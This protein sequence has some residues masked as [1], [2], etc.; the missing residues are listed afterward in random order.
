MFAPKAIEAVFPSN[1]LDQ[2]KTQHTGAMR[3]SRS[4]MVNKDHI[5]QTLTIT[6]DLL[7][8]NSEFPLKSNF[9]VG[10]RLLSI[11]VINLK[12]IE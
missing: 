7:C 3:R 5:D 1:R 8:E 11:L 10:G 6:K 2:Y 4:I 9:M 12:I